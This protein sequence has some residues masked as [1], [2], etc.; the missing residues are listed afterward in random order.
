MSTVIH[1]SEDCETWFERPTVPV[2]VSHEQLQRLL[3][4][5]EVSEAV[6]GW[7]DDVRMSRVLE[8]FPHA[9]FDEDE[10]GF[11]VIHTCDKAVVT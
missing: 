5:A 10:D 8:I 11:L 1:V 7:K 9:I 4:G 6:P 3:D 2:L